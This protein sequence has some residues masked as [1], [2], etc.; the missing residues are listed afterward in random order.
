M[1]MRK[2]IQPFRIIIIEAATFFISVA[3]FFVLDR[4]YEITYKTF[5][6]GVIGKA[7]NSVWEQT[8]IVFLT[9]FVFSFIELYILNV[10]FIRFFVAKTV[11]MLFITLALPGFLYGYS[12]AI[13]LN[14]KV[15][16][17]IGA[18]SILFFAFV[19]SSK[20]ML[21]KTNNK[22]FVLSFICFAFMLS[23]FLTLTVYAPHLPFFKDPKTG[24][25][26]LETHL[27]FVSNNTFF[28]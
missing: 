13:G 14:F 4:L 28:T 3:A 2:E 12:G 27:I 9:F 21:H 17:L 18:I 19:I 1:L 23:C 5:W 16:D 22:R 15:I 7:N 6:A 24:A 20:I 26:G 10:P 8:K 25:V 11:G